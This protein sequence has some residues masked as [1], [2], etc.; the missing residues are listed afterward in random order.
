MP[1]L[2]SRPLL[3]L[4]S[5]RS[6]IK[7]RV[8]VADPDPD[9]RRHVRHALRGAGYHVDEADDG[10]ELIHAISA[11]IELSTQRGADYTSLSL[12]VV[13]AAMPGFS[14][15]EA[16]SMLQSLEWPTPVILTRSESI[17]L[18]RIAGKLD[19]AQILDKPFTIADLCARMALTMPCS[20]SA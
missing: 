19:A 3:T 13:D 9:L 16:L 7:R 11:D 5:S 15:L 12:I 20:H 18:D 2:H 14:G 4:R 1:S 17:D 6:A 10:L 8:L